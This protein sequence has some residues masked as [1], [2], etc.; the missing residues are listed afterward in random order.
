MLSVLKE[1]VARCKANIEE[2]VKYIGGTREFS[3]MMEESPDVA[4]G[5]TWFEGVV[6]D[7]DEKL[8]KDKYGKCS[9]IIEVQESYVLERDANYAY[10]ERKRLFQIGLDQRLG[11]NY[12][13]GLFQTK[14]TLKEERKVV[15]P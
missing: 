12:H 10:A 14:H 4:Q 9:S 2:A 3:F 5:L 1:I 13:G 7:W 6:D 15:S 11:T 8:K